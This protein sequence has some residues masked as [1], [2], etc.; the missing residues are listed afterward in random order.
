MG[1]PIY[2]AVF[3]KERRAAIERGASLSVMICPRVAFFI[4]HFVTVQLSF[5]V[6]RS[7]LLSR[8]PSMAHM[9]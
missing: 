8:L 1:H 6:D 2:E 4:P 7:K 5:D 9:N 3:T